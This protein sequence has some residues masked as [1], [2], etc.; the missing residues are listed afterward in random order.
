MGDG[1]A[2]DGEFERWY[3]LEHPRVVAALSVAGGDVDVA[4]EATDEAFVR[5]YERWTRVRDMSSPGGWLYRVALHELRRK[6]RRRTLE[7]ELLRRQPAQPVDEP[8]PPVADPRVWEAVRQLPRR[9]RSAIA[10]RYVLDLSE[11]D[12]AATMGIS[13]GAAS[14]SLST[15]RK[16]LQAAL[17]EPVDPVDPLD[18]PHPASGHEQRAAQLRG[19][20]LDHAVERAAFDG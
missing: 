6:Q 20:S 17:A 7:R 11:Q 12:V 5:A 10:L 16:H 9:Q 2:D 18:G 14:A 3:R 19:S 15:A 4:R 13:R 1:G 8:T